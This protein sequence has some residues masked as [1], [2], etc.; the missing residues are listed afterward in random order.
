M[1]VLAVIWWA[2]F[3]FEEW[4]ERAERFCNSG[5]NIDWR[6]EQQGLAKSAASCKNTHNIAEAASV[7]L[8]TMAI[9]DEIRPLAKKKIVHFR[10]LCFSAAKRD[11]KNCFLY[12]ES[13]AKSVGFNEYG[14]LELYTF[15]CTLA[16]GV[17]F[18]FF[19]TFCNDHHS[20]SVTQD[21]W[22]YQRCMWSI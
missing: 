7:V 12:L 11:Q 2:N 13:V 18:D 1:P 4:G 3:F 6:L 21:E 9:S 8:A 10:Y 5:D 14:R 16:W 15:V 19:S 22:K 17:V 20:H